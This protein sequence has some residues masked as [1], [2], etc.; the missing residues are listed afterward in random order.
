M[1]FEQK[2][3]LGRVDLL[4]RHLTLQHS[5]SVFNKDIED[6]L[7][8]SKEELYEIMYQLQQFNYLLSNVYLNQNSL[9]QQGYSG[10]VSILKEQEPLYRNYDANTA[11]EVKNV[12]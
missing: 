3:N 10:L 7:E 1:K 6:K 5:D 8:L 11:K 9:E 2:G 4:I 12:F